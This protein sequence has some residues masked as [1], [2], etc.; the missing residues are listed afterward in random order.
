MMLNLI[1][2]QKGK[3]MGVIMFEINNSEKFK[4][5]LKKEVYY[6]YMFYV[7]AG[8]LFVFTNVQICRSVYVGSDKET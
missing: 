8:G 4:K 1:N 7:I 5:F 2:F 6:K 3:S